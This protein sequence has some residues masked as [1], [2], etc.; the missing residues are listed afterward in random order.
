MDLQVS[1]ARACGEEGWGMSLVDDKEDVVR[2]RGGVPVTAVALGSPADAAGV[3]VGDVISHVA[4]RKVW[5]TPLASSR[6][7]ADDG[8][9]TPAVPLPRLPR[10]RRP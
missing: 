9:R 10:Y 6:C 4:G 2:Q 3:A 7:L 8:P 5:A 1:L